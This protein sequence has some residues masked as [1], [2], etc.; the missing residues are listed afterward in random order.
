MGGSPPAEVLDMGFAQRPGNPIAFRVVAQRVIP[1]AERSVIGSVT[2]QSGSTEH[3]QNPRHKSS[4][5]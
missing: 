2:L 3:A 4:C 1:D 5:P